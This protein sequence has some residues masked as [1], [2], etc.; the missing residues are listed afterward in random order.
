MD[1]QNSGIFA[2]LPPSLDRRRLASI[3]IDRSLTL[4][5]ARWRGSAVSLGGS[6]VAVARSP[7]GVGRPPPLPAVGLRRSLAESGTAAMLLRSVASR[8]VGAGPTVSL[9]RALQ[10]VSR[11]LEARRAALKHARRPACPSTRA[12]RT[13]LR[14]FSM[15]QSCFLRNWEPCK[16]PS[17]SHYSSQRR[18][19]YRLCRDLCCLL[20]E[21]CIMVVR[22]LSWLCWKVKPTFGDWSA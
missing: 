1:V 17:L 13:G 3:I 22:R 2:N 21:S 4:T 16:H 14:T 9:A 18:R 8:R 19:F 11:A 5:V 15:I 20:F 12:R 7:D 6:V 10:T